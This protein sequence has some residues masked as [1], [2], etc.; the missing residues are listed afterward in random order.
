MYVNMTA[1]VFKGC[2][3]STLVNV[4]PS[5]SHKSISLSIIKIIRGSPVSLKSLVCVYHMGGA[6][7]MSAE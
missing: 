4:H 1:I 2:L 7:Q 3:N 6:Q 5:L